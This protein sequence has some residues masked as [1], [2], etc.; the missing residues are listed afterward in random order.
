MED[1]IFVRSVAT[2]DRQH[3]PL[4]R[5]LDS[6]F[7]QASKYHRMP[8]RVNFYIVRMCGMFHRYVLT[9]SCSNCPDGE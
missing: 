9:G 2:T 6:S 3:I 8:V 4:K 1:Y 7:H 5:L